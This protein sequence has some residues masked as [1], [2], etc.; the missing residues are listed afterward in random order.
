MTIEI[1]QMVIKS[2][3]QDGAGKQVAK[4]TA[5][6]D[7]CGDCSTD[8]AGSTERMRLRATLTIEL[9]RLMER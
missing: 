6:D 8:H 1:R 2:S 4:E 7:G 5:Q 3:I 9:T